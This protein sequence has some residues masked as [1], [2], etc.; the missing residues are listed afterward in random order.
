MYIF[1]TANCLD[2]PTKAGR[3]GKI[4]AENIPYN[5]CFWIY[6]CI[7]KNDNHY[8]FIISNSLKISYSE[9]KG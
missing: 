6:I 3:P 4:Y 2:Q 5:I 9:S 7:K 8:Q 1:N